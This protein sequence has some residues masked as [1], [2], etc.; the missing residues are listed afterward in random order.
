M[1]PEPTPIL[2]PP[3][4][5]PISP[6]RDKLRLRFRKDAALRMLSHHDLM[7]CF[8]RMLRRA[9]LPVRQSQGFHPKPR[10]VFALSL[11]LGV[12]GCE[13]VVELELEEILPPEEVCERLKRQAPPGLEILSLRRIG[14]KTGA[15][16]H[17][18]TYR[19]AITADRAAEARRRAA[20]ALAASECWTERS[21]PAPRRVNLR[22]WIVDV[23]F[24]GA[25]ALEMELCLTPAGTARP[26]EVLDLLG[27]SDLLE[28]GA[29]LERSRLTLK[30][31]G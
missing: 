29:V 4:P 25:A 18:L 8:E 13:E 3:I 19:I 22:P 15:Q 12:I 21:R 27:L 28:A 9:V 17:S 11:P 23:R 24:C 16:V 5:G 31:E 20:E 1:A 10:L 2:A 7:R 30:D 14:V 6:T 26:E